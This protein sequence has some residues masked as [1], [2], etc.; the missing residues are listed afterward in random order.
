ML[1]RHDQKTAL[2]QLNNRHGLKRVGDCQQ[3][4]VSAGIPR[5]GPEPTHRHRSASGMLHSSAVVKGLCNSRRFGDDPPAIMIAMKKWDV[6]VGGICRVIGGAAAETWIIMRFF[7]RAQH[8]RRGQSH[9]PTGHERR[10]RG[11]GADGVGGD[12]TV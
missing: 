1:N 4:V 11:V 9:P 2:Y 12:Q 6:I 3:V 7:H 8:V 10:Q 5:C